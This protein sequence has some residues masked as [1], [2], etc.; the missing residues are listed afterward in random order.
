M[1][2]NYPV[3][4]SPVVPLAT[5]RQIGRALLRWYKE[6]QRDLPW[7]KSGDPY[8][9][10]VSEIM[11]QQTR[12]ESVREYYRRWML[13]FPSLDLLAA[14]SEQDVLRRWQGLGYYSRARNLH[15]AAQMVVAEWGGK[16]PKLPK[17]LQRL[18]GIG[19]YSAGAIASIAFRQDVPIV[20]GNVVRVLCR[21]FALDTDPTRAP[22]KN[23]LW[24]IAE[25]LIVKGQ[26]GA[27]NQALMELGALVCTPQ[28]PRCSDC[29]LSR[30]CEAHRLNRTAS[31]PALPKAAA[32]TRVRNIAV[33]AT[34]RSR[35][36]VVQRPQDARRWP[37]MWEFPNMDVLTKTQIPSTINK[38]LAPLGL[39]IQDRKALMSFHHA[40][41]RYRIEV[42]AFAATKISGKLR[43]RSAARWVHPD[44][45]E[46]LPMP[47][48]QRRIARALEKSDL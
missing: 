43:P 33:V 26:A 47:A 20:D 35:V 23:T 24:E 5:R 4:N 3:T 34:R 7:R 36:L 44:D 28:K 42:E 12:V 9:V 22:L 6:H 25:S 40:V 27:F 8:A 31:L 14:A 13:A 17:E 46:E 10:W 32:V 11:L 18:P 38:L 41:T 1:T 48:A 16:L 19:P 15:R 2:A 29:P 39:E 21:L 30:V 37:S 45:L